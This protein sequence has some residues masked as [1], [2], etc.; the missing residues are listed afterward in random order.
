MKLT[1]GS[2]IM[3]LYLDDISNNEKNIN[4][5]MRD[6][7]KEKKGFFDARLIKLL[8][9]VSETINGGSSNIDIISGYLHNDKLTLLNNRS[10]HDYGIYMHTQGKAIDFNISKIPAEHVFK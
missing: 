4:H 6:R 7:N 9:E 3:F 2:D 1:F 8:F 10:R 5:F